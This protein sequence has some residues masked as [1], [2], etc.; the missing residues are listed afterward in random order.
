MKIGDVIAT[1]Y[2]QPLIRP[3][4]WSGYKADKGFEMLFLFLGTQPR[5]GSDDIDV[6]KRICQL[7]WEMTPELRAELIESG[8]IK[9]DGD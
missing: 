6:V 3:K 1:T 7:G 8:M 9:D 4:G 2:I 5:D